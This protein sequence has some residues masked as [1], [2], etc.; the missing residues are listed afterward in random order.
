M[1]ITAEVSVNKYGFPLVTCYRCAGAGRFGPTSVE[2]G[3]CFGCAGSGIR[4][5]RG[6]ATKAWTAFVTA[7][8]RFREPTPVDIE[9]GQR[10][11]KYLGEQFRT[12]A[13]TRWVM[14]RRSAGGSTIGS[15]DNA[16]TS[17]RPHIEV[18]FTF[19]NG[20]VERW[21]SNQTIRRAG[22]V[23]PAPYLA[24]AGVK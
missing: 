14:G 11:A 17:S 13:A 1:S 10:I 20:D 5:K 23:D 2:G 16:V 19:D 18:E 12:V 3:R 7:H 8:H 9:V 21:V 22:T 4:V 24:Q 6:K 15:G